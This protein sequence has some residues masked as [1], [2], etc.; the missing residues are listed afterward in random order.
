M[1]IDMKLVCKH[2][3]SS[4]DSIVKE[5]YGGGVTLYIVPCINCIGAAQQGVRAVYGDYC[6]CKDDD[7]EFQEDGVWL[8]DICHRPRR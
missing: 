1:K 5:G 7:L 6:A 4:I 3:G 8:C 2:C